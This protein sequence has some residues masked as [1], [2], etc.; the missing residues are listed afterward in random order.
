MLSVLLTFFSCGGNE[1]EV[2]DEPKDSVVVPPP[3]VEYGFVL[4]SFNVERDT[5]QPG[6]TM[7]HMF[8]GYGLSQYEINVAAELAAD[9]LVG[10]KY[11]KEGTPYIMLSALG[12]TSGRLQYCIYPKNVVDYV[13]FD[14]RDSV[15]VEKHSK[16]SEVN[17]R[18]ITGE[19]IKNSNLTVALNQQLKDLNLTG[20]LAE[21]I[22][23]VFAWTIDFFRLYP[24]DEFK[25][26]YDEKSVEGSPYG[27]GKINSAWFKSSRLTTVPADCKRTLSRLNSTAVRSMA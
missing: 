1:E 10:L 14:F 9:S 15:Y 11:I 18:T 27:V 2:T 12:D 3:V 24:G 22:A 16:S 17:E 5:V 7:S 20:E 21:Y 13:V 19:I 23:G 25:I 6:W 4:D 26:V 8:Q